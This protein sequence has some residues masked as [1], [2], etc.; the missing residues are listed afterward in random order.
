ME[1]NPPRTRPMNFFP[2]SPITLILEAKPGLDL[3]SPE[4][5]RQRLGE[6]CVVYRP[7]IVRWMAC[8]GMADHQE[9]LAHDFLERWLG[10]NPLNGYERG[11]CRFRDFLG[12]SLRNFKLERLRWLRREKRGGD[13]VHLDCEEV[14]I[15]AATGK[16]AHSLDVLVV[17][18]LATAA[19]GALHE[20]LRS[21][22]AG[23]RREL[24]RRIWLQEEIAYPD[25]ARMLGTSVKAT[26]LRVGRLRQAYLKAFLAEVRTLCRHRADVEREQI[27]LLDLF[28]QEVT[29][30]DWVD[31]ALATWDSSV[32]K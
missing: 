32:G 18:Q 1:L 7:S 22:P 8:N 6:L 9:D 31:E 5:W 23:V 27:V 14:D 13:V 29:A 21:L 12:A 2:T 26:R 19:L 28:C 20:D 16:E 10:G 17:R 25:L 30:S 3:T 11:E 15:P 24:L 4:R